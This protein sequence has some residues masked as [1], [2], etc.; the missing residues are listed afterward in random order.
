MGGIAIVVVVVVV[1]A[2]LTMILWRFR[3]PA[4]RTRHSSRLARRNQRI[5]EA[6]AADVAAMRE[7]ARFVR[8]DAPGDHQDEL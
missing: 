1:V 7:G 4:W 6:A 8:R 2:A 5:Q 3:R